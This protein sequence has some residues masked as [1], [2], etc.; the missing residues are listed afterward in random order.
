MSRGLKTDSAHLRSPVGAH[1]PEPT[2]SQRH[3]SSWI[4]PALTSFTGPR[5]GKQTGSSQREGG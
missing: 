1:R 3:G 5:V 4:R 2:G